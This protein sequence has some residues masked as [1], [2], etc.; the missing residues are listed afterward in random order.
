MA[1]R[2]Q[3]PTQMATGVTRV[4][5]GCVEEG[6]LPRPSGASATDSRGVAGIPVEAD[7]D[8]GAWHGQAEKLSQAKSTLRRGGGSD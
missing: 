6:G 5:W 8:L 2:Q 1:S 4:L 7:V 3:P